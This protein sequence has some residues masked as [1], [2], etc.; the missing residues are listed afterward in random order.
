MKE[1][2]LVLIHGYPF[3]HTIWF[4]TIAS[5]GAH[6]RVIA[7]DL[8]GFGRNAVLSGQ[9]PSLEAFADFIAQVLDGNQQET[10]AIAGMSMG[11][12][13]ALAFAEKYPARLAGL[14]MISSQAAADT[15]ET[16]QGRI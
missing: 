3:D 10:A 13:V 6:A 1:V 5:L 9:S 15:P 14:G 8:P 12:Y 4:S 2:P 16:R 11:G 7:P